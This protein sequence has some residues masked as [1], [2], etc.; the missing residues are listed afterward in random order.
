MTTQ[1]ARN[2]RKGARFELDCVEFFRKEGFKVERLR[3]AG[4]H[5]EGDLAIEDEHGV[6]VVECKDEQKFNLSGWVAE[7][8]VERDNYCKARGLDPATV[9][10]LV[11]AKRRGKGVK[12]AYC[13]SPVTEHFDL[14]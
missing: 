13:I 1:Q 10:A 7:S 11:I 5:D 6:I 8:L 12:D 2:K 4:K 14:D 9:G 3:L